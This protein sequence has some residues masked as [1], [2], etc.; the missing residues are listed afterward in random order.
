MNIDEARALGAMA[1]FGEK[2]GDRVRVVSIG[3]DWSREL[4]AG[5]HVGRSAEVGLISLVSESSVGASNRRV[6]ALVGLDAFR[7]LAAERA[8]VSQLTGS[9]KTPRDQLPAKIAELAASLKAAE[10]K[11][12][13]FESRAL[14]DRLPQLVDSAVA[15]GSV[16][17]VA[18]SLGTAATADD[19]RS[20]ALQVRDRLGSE[21]AVAALGALVGD[22]VAVVVATNDAARA[23]GVKAGALA[24]AAAA[25]L[26]GGGG[27]RDDVAQG[28]GT[29]AAALP[30]A[31]DAIVAAVRTTA[32]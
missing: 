20:L 22:R 27:G 8:I 28:G 23:R 6:E 4:C 17:V 10:K 13:A 5:T 26:G 1:L 7:E 15:A 18:Q 16:R 29:D 32:A 2:Y 19:V 3:G 24:K 31:L 21:P 9:L 11:I 12:A 25:A 30:G 14:A